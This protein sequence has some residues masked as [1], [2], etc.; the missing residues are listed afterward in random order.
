MKTRLA[1]RLPFFLL[2]FAVA[3]FPFC[4]GLAAGI[5]KL[6]PA[7]TALQSYYDTRNL[8]L[9]WR[10]DFELEPSR[11]L[12]EN[13]PER[14]EPF[15]LHKP[16]ALG[17]GYILVSGLTPGEATINGARLL[18]SSGRQIHFWPFDYDAVDPGGP[19]PWNV[20]QHGISVL[21]D[22]SAIV[23]F[24]AGQRL[25][26][27]GACGEVIWSQEGSYHH[28]TSLADDGTLWTLRDDSLVQIDP[29]NGEPLAEIDL[30]EELIEK[31]G[32]HDILALRSEENAED[33][34]EF[35]HDPLHGN[36]VE[37]LPAALADAFPLFEAGD[38]LISLRN[39]NL[40]GVLD[41]ETLE[42][43]WWSIGP[44]HRQHD[45]HFGADG[46]IL[47]YN[48][49]M[50]FP[51]S[52]ILAIDPESRETEV[53]FAG[54]EARPFY[55]YRRGKF[56]QLADGSLLIAESERGRVFMVDA[57][58]ELVFEYNNRYDDTQNGVVS[59]AIHLPL[60][61]FE[62]GALDCAAAPETS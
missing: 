19:A 35:S 60:D 52:E 1:E 14:S 5:W 38:L 30:I 20:F 59:A 7:E 26:R 22:G 58:G 25:A 44:W 12:V 48:N 24:D 61:F 17:D 49:D 46:R 31:Q 10:N 55:S 51:P 29:A 6:P 2:L 9:N 45:P 37:A 11:H 32:R 21:P 50:N 54:S 13:Y 56:Q 18:D 15:T 33:E 4:Y 8:V 43:K 62:A 27:F 16:E 39:L 41:G 42:M 28:A 53:L 57:G 36:H 3:F 47:V 40:V 34:F 23:N